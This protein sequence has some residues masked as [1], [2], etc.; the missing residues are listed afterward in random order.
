MFGRDDDER[1][2][3]QIIDTLLTIDGDMPISIGDVIVRLGER[4]FGV[5]LILLAIPTLIPILPPG[6]SGINGILYIVSGLQMLGGRRQLWLPARVRRYRFSR[7]SLDLLRQRGVSTLRR[8][9]RY[10]RP[11]HTP[12]SDVALLRLMAIPTLAMGIILWL[13]MPLMNTLPGM[14][15]MMIGIGIL[16]EDGYFLISGS[17]LAAGVLA[18]VGVF[19]NELVHFFKWVLHLMPG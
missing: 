11:R 8:M 7:R 19:F 3:S 17:A 13:P 12:F 4:A 2:V 14:A 5:V 16:N 9:E 6:A 15:M 1:P 10:S 18:L